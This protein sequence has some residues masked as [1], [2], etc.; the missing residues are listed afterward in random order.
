MRPMIPLTAAISAALIAS[1]AASGVPWQKR[2]L[3]GAGNFEVI[4]GSGLT[5]RRIWCEAGDYAFR[6]MG[7]SGTSRLY[8]LN[9]NGWSKTNRLRRGTGFTIQPTPEVLQAAERERGN[10]SVSVSRVGY[11]LSVSQARTYCDEFVYEW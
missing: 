11:N 5:N 6:F 10:V 9:P 3:P 7:A 2:A 1:G 8:I 4:D